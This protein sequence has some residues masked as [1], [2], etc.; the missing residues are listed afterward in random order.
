M[1]EMDYPVEVNDSSRLYLNKKFL[2]V[3]RLANSTVDSKAIVDRPTKQSI[4]EVFNA[5]EAIQDND[6][7]AAI[8]FVKD[9]LGEPGSEILKTGPIDWK[10]S[11]QFINDLQSLELK[12]LG[13][14]LNEIWLDLYRKVDPNQF[15]NG[16]VTSHLP[17]IH[18]FV[19]PGGRFREMYYWDTYWTIEGL[20]V[21]DMH[22]T[23]RMMLENFINFISTYG[24]IPNGSRVY[25][26]N[27]SQPPYFAQ[28]VLAY[29]EY[30]ISSNMSQA[31]KNEIRG[32]VL[33]TALPAIVKEYNYWMTNKIVKVTKNNKEYTLN[34]FKVD[35]DAPRPE[36]YNEDVETAS[37][38]SNDKD[39]ARVYADLASAAESGYDFSTR[40]FKD[41]YKLET[42]QTTN[43]IPVDL[44]TLIYKME[45]ILTEFY[46]LRGDTITANYY[47]N[48]SKERA[49]SINDVLWSESKSYWADYDIVEDELNDENFYVFGLSPLWFDI[50]PPNKTIAEVINAN[51]GNYSAY[52]GGIPV[53]F[54]NSSQQW[55]FPNVWA[56]NQH[57]IIF[58]LLKY[59]QSSSLEIARNFFNT[60]YQGWKKYDLFYEKYDA[61]RPGERG[62]GGEYTVQSGFGWTNGVTLQLLKTFKD[63]LII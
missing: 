46:N 25:Y 11:P 49:I 26:L 52:P 43:L 56:P 31:E 15:S 30:S 3:G 60:V 13:K 62:S 42:I 48:R 51:F 4:D 8:K 18:P 22:K 35:N 14:A 7:E 34:Q 2:Q 44:N 6:Q 10:S 29:Y 23:V 47:E 36:S 27:R 24:H 9:Y 17:M 12:R 37:H 63:D 21:C 53:S 54:I 59:N 50:S 45:T 33:H 20:L 55:D 16:L 58:M 5:L 61:T 39:K 57:S 41:P 19:V 28:M 38:F 32:F 40:W 1:F